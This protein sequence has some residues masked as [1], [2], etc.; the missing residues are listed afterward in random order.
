VNWMGLNNFLSSNRAGIAF[1]LVVMLAGSIAYFS[2]GKKDMAPVDVSE[3]FLNAKFKVAYAEDGSMKVFALANSEGLAK[4]SAMEGR[5][6]PGAKSM[7][8]G[9]DEA[10]MMRSEE[11]FFGP[12]D[13]IDGLFNISIIVGGVL[14]MTN[15]PVDMIHFL[16]K[17]K[18]SELNGEEGRVFVKLKG[19]TPKVFYY[20]KV[21]EPPL[22]KFE[23]AEGSLGDYNIQ[24]I[25]GETYFPIIFGSSEAKM[26]KEEGLFSKPGDKIKGFFGKNV[27]V[28]GV[29]NEQKS[30]ADVMHFIPLK[31]NDLS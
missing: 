2:F 3:V 19:K 14:Q 23:L 1:A 21:N 7:V 18:F 5:N 25:G 24:Q 17:E 6:T 10:K 29:L 15:S 4:L 30:A 28:A 22:K 16:S 20:L 27:F 12:G 9:A 26:M 8:L 31:E 13:K 11:L